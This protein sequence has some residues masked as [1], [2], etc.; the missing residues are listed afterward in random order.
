MVYKLRRFTNK[1]F[2][3]HKTLSKKQI[4]KIKYYR[5]NPAKFL[6]DYYGI[7]LYWW[8]KALLKIKPNQIKS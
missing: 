7:K 2:Q 4:E 3:Y 5:K 6:E 1:K 8:Q